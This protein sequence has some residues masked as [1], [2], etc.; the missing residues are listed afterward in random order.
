MKECTEHLVANRQVQREDPGECRE[1]RQ[2]GPRGPFRA[3]GK[4]KREGHQ[5]GGEHHPVLLRSERHRIGE[6]DEPHSGPV[7]AKPAQVGQ[8]PEQHE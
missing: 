7:R 3:P 1:H 8:S 4:E 6:R 2:L 5:Q